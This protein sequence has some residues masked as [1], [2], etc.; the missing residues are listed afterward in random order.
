MRRKIIKSFMCL[1][2]A[3]SLLAP[4]ALVLA[5]NVSEE[6]K[7]VNAKAQSFISV[8]N[9][10]NLNVEIELE[11]PLNMSKDTWGG[12]RVTLFSDEHGTHNPI[13][14]NDTNQTGSSVASK[15]FFDFKKVPI[16]NYKLTIEKDGGLSYEQ[17]ITIDNSNTELK[18]I[19]TNIPEGKVHYIANQMGIL[20]LGDVNDD[21]IINDEDEK[22]MI[23]QIESGKYSSLYD[24]NLDGSIDIVD[25]S[26][27]S[28]NKGKGNVTA[29]PLKKV[30]VD[31]ITPEISKDTSIK[32][33]NINDILT[34]N[35]KFI[36]LAP[37]SE[38]DISEDNP[39]QIT[40][41]LQNNE[42]ESRVIVIA[43]SEN[44]D[45]N[46]KSGTLIVEKDDGSEETIP[47]SEPVGINNEYK[48]TKYISEET[49]IDENGIMSV[50]VN[51]RAG[52]NENEGSSVSFAK[53]GSLVIDLG[54]QVAIKK[55][56]IK[57]TGTNSNKLADIA[58]VEFLNGMEDRIPEPEMDIPT[59]L[60][61]ETASEEITVTWDKMNNVTGYEVEV[62]NDGKAEITK[63]N[64]NTATITRFNNDD[65][66]NGTTYIIRVQS[67]NGA[68]KSG[69]SEPI[70]VTPLATRKPPAPNMVTVEGATKSLNVSWKD[71]KDTDYYD[72]YYRVSG[73]GSYI[74]ANSSPIT[75]PSYKIEGLTV[76]VTYQ[77]YV[78]GTNQLGE[79]AHSNV[80]TGSPI[81]TSP[82]S[83]PKYKLINKPQVD[84]EGNEINGALTQNIKS[85]QIL[86]NLTYNGGTADTF[87]AAGKLIDSSLDEG[88]DTAEYK[89]A[90][91]VVD[92]DY[93]SYYYYYDWDVGVSAHNYNPQ[94]PVVEF[95]EPHTM[96]YFALAHIDSSEDTTG[97]LVYYWDEQGNMKKFDSSK[98]TVLK[99]ADLTGRTYYVVKL[100]EPITAT[101]VAINLQRYS[102]GIT[103]AEISYYDYDSLEHDINNLFKDAMHLELVSGVTS[104]DSTESKLDLADL[105]RRLDTQIDGEYNP[106]RDLLQNE[107]NTAKDIY[108]HRETL[109]KIVEIDPTVTKAKDGHITFKSGLNEW[110]P[111]GVVAHAGEEIVVYV[112]SPNKK[113]GDNT[114]IYLVATQYHGEANKWS[115]V[116]KTPLK[117]GPNV[118]TV[119]EISNSNSRESGGSLYIKYTGNNVNDKYSV[120]VSGGVQIPVLDLTKVDGKK[121][122]LAAVKAYVAE[123]EER[124]TEVK[125]LHNEY[126]NASDG[127]LVGIDKYAEDECIIGATEIVL[128]QMMLSVSTHQIYTAL[129][130]SSVD[131]KA[132]QLYNSL[133]AMNDMIDLFYA[134]KG[135]SKLE[136]AGSKNQYPSS[137]LNIRYQTMFDGA[138]MYA[139]G[140][141]IGIE[142]P[143]IK[144]LATAT[145]IDSVNGLYKE[146]N[147]FGW[148]IAH[149]IGHIINEPAYAHAEVTNNYFSVLA[150]AKDNNDSVRFDYKNVYDKVT[151]GTI[152]KASNVFT[153]LGLYWQLHLA[154]DTGY[155]FKMYDNYEDQF[156][157]LF[158]ARVDTYA[159]DTSKA[160]NALTLEGAD[161]DNKLMRLAIA[162]AEENILPFFESWGMVPDKDTIKYAKKFSKETRKIQYINDDARAYQLRGEDRMPL[163]TAITKNDVSIKNNKNSNEVTIILGNNND[164]KFGEDSP[165]LGYEITRSYY[166]YGEKISRAVGFVT[167][168]D[169]FIDTIDS[170]NNRV[171]TYSVVA[172]DKYLNETKP[173]EFAP[174]KISH[175]GS[176]EKDNWVITTTLVSK[177]DN[178][179]D[180]EDDDPCAPEVEQAISRI[181][182]KGKGNNE[183]NGTFSGDNGVIYITLPEPTDII[184]FKYEKGE[185]NLSQKYT[186]SISNNSGDS[187]KDWV[188]VATGT[189]ANEEDEVTVY[190]ND[191]TKD[192]GVEGNVYVHKAT[193]VRITLTG[194]SKEVS[195]DEISLLG[196]QGDNV[197]I[198][199]VGSYNAIGKLA[200]D[201]VYDAGTLEDASD[202]QYIP[203][204]SI[205]FMG[206]Y[207]GNPAYNVVVLY[208]A[209]TGM[210]V[211]SDDG[212]TYSLIFANVPK[213]GDIEK[214]SEGYWLYVIESGDSIYNELPENVRAELYRV[215]DATKLEGERYVSDSKVVS[216]PET[217]SKLY[218]TGDDKFN[219]K[220]YK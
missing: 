150:Q 208:D 136:E 17:D 86:L 35:E 8:S 115:E 51:N 185:G 198:G 110:Q 93:T 156:E 118:I 175:D 70:R 120:R 148:G 103:V 100:S 55:V 180:A 170:M 203:E 179:T 140:E 89:S 78:V 37:A 63:V 75:R 134:H 1:S 19:D 94:T 6:L 74:K 16:G 162:A 31:N 132:E 129:K 11:L 157:N 41:D 154:Y 116:I 187:E 192:G 29:T 138:F 119:P 15:L 64:L 169:T 189:F 4:N 135:L 167:E 144:G 48:A 218:L 193:Y 183:Y 201:F 127:S 163:D 59:N 210:P 71:M 45:N 87:S 212:L 18:F 104:G 34:N 111:L 128:D 195:I 60:K 32:S 206:V 2:M 84:E 20:A 197:D 108:E 122:E 72:V 109:R 130:G 53:D 143:E 76:G 214:V 23:N 124:D 92:N 217:L 191:G 3:F 215:D 26:Y 194:T 96:Y 186:V 216:V 155:N 219:K 202:D 22:V 82:A 168:G 126:H 14:S 146:G 173:Y 177:D 62:S 58:K 152:G 178:T 113:T 200:E 101:K 114:N 42:Q 147:Y 5:A 77:V 97:A 174:I 25:L 164:L 99:K 95:T 121:A 50:R 149:E 142:W 7:Q 165:L 30:N 105:Q 91:G 209:D 181:A 52:S 102:R 211:A 65:I 161:T 47:F 27:V 67:V 85:A 106:E 139:G 196:K 9:T 204:D 184:G 213:E 90:L 79:G 131:D 69:Y 205:V 24:L 125:T 112:G 28:F 40:L 166:E 188:D 10:G 141:H 207:S 83:M 81:N 98:T 133:L 54:T 12:Y 36:S 21:N 137:R 43:P 107:L 39:V 44:P 68:W 33:G 172:I 117:I 151:S 66:K 159:R 88:K 171:F 80:V 56:T 182:D 199:E 13:K 61:A 190:F 46:I 123:L 73:H 57:V 158:F 176:I 145:P 160:P 153:Q 38:E 220:Q 49:F